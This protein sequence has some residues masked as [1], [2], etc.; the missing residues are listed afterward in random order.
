MKE[1]KSDRFKRVATKRTQIVISKIDSLQTLSSKLSYE[2]S[3]EQV[4]ALL[5]SLHE[6]V[7]RVENAFKDKVELWITE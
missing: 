3:Q 5:S 6:A 4:E 1:T 7:A 2:Y